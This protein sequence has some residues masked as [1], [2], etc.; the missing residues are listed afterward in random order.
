MVKGNKHPGFTT[1]QTKIAKQQGVSKKSAGAIL[2]AS[3]RSAS[4]TAKR[5]NPKLKK[6]K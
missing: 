1:V 4:A 2:A 6:V 3:T 5:R